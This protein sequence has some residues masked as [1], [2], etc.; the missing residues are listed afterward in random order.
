MLYA[1]C[2]E[3]YT[4]NL[5]T[6]P[7]YVVAGFIGEGHRW[8]LFNSLWSPRAVE[9]SAQLVRRGAEEAGRDPDEV[10]IWTILVTACEVSTNGCGHS[11]RKC[12]N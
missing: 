5:K 9:R 3:S 12:P 7:I 10:T 4:G 11:R 1:Y 6:T 2:D 8:E